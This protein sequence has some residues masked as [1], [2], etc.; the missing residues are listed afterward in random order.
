MHLCNPVHFS[1]ISQVISIFGWLELVDSSS[2]PS[3]SSCCHLQCV[4]C[5]LLLCNKL[6]LHSTLP[7]PSLILLVQLLGVLPP[8]QPESGDVTQTQSTL[9]GVIST[10]A[11][12]HS[13]HFSFPLN[14]CCHLMMGRAIMA[15]LLDRSSDMSA[16]M[17][18]SNCRA[19]QPLFCCTGATHM[20][21]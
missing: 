20:L 7:L 12:V 18:H 16:C 13:A 1:C 21:P 3:S 4:A 2:S 9:I 17:L 8:Q 10:L 5:R 19:Q 15:A 11:E 6:L 14:F